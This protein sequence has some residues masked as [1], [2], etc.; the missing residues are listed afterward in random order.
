MTIGSM[1]DSMAEL[2]RARMGRDLRGEYLAISEPWRSSFSVRW[3]TF[4]W[5]EGMESSRAMWYRMEELYHW[6]W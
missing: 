5:E 2:G 3:M 4:K 1:S 6:T